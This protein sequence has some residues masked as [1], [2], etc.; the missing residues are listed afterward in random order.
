MTTAAMSP[1][2]VAAPGRGPDALRS[3]KAPSA[4]PNPATEQFHLLQKLL[5]RRA[6]WSSASPAKRGS[7]RAWWNPVQRLLPSGA[8]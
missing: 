7:A 5:W 6:R 3:T 1:S 2:F 8:Q 4:T